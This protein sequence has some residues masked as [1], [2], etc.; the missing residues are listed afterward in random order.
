M[1]CEPI[2][3]RNA[4]T[5][6]V[7]LS[8]GRCG[9][10]LVQCTLEEHPDVEV[11]GEIFQENQYDRSRFSVIRG[12]F[13]RDGTDAAQFLEDVVFGGSPSNVRAVGFKLMY[14]QAR[15]S[16]ASLRAWDLLR[17]DTEIRVI[18]LNRRDLLECCCSYEVASRS[19]QW[20]LPNLEERI[21][22]RPF[23][24]KPRHFIGFC[25]SVL[26]W[27]AWARRAFSDHPVLE[28]QYEQDLCADF[29][30]AMARIQEFVGLPALPLTP[31]IRKQAV[32]APDR[33]LSNFAE[34]KAACRH[35]I[36][37]E[38]F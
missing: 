22:V 9:S 20:Y 15:E 14:G 25:E 37:E 27:R 17:A 29:P 5:K 33:Q 16:A 26:A 35:T 1:S 31:P 8:Y 6:F 3:P 34:L 4:K 13:Y 10:T 38:F 36:A 21:A 7:I 23:R 11:F 24:L 18:H 32:V 12:Q 19:Q 2:K 28:V 30:G